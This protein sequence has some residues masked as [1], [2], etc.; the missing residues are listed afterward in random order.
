[1]QYESLMSM[2]WTHGTFWVFI[3][4]VI[5]AVLFGR[6]IV[7]PVGT[8]LDQRAETVRQSLEEASRLKAEAEDML[9]NAKK[10]RA[11]ALAEAKDILARA[12]EE[13]VRT[14]ADLAAEAEARARARERMAQERIES[15]QASAIAEV[16]TAAI[17]IAIAATTEA[18]RENLTA[19]GDARLID[20][21]IAEV[22]SAF[23]HRAA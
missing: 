19:A 17:E 10:K 5:F 4:I 14:A 6:K 15:A 22:P 11:Q 21:A 3:A 7:V 12:K 16:R 8:M 13:A 23:T 9:A 18:L 2:P 1:M 20:H